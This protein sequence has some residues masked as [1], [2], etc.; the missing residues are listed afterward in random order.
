MIVVQYVTL[1]AVV[2]GPEAM[3]VRGAADGPCEMG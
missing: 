2:E 3:A 1:D